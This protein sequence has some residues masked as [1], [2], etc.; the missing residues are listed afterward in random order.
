MDLCKNNDLIL[1]CS[2]GPCK[3]RP[4]GLT[5]NPFAFSSLST[6][7]TKIKHSWVALF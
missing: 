4:K 2:I 6:N 3:N 7:L 5:V 1:N